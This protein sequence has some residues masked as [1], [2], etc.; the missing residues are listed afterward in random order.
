MQRS[1][2]ELSAIH[3]HI[4]LVWPVKNI[5]DALQTLL[6]HGNVEG[7]AQILAQRV[8][9][10]T[11]DNELGS[12]AFALLWV[13]LPLLEENVERFRVLRPEL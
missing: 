4:E 12:D 3:V 11:L 13:F 1:A 7:R 8:R 6:L 2:H 5:P 10:E 9:V